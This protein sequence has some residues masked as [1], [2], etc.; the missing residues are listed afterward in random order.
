MKVVMVTAP[1]QVEVVDVPEP[2]PGPRDIVVR[3][4]ACGI[5]G[6][7]AFYI[8]IGGIPPRQGQTI[9]G[10]E[11]PARWWRSAPR[12]RGSRWATMW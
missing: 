2:A 11:G 5:C 10:H 4:R 8:S 7:D 3:P 12:W 6:S 9:L 1:G